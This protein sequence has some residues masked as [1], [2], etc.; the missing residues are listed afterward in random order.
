MPTYTQT[1]LPVDLKSACRC[2]ES[3]TWR[4]Q[5]ISGRQDDATVVD[6][7]SEGR[8]GRTAYGEVPGEEVFFGWGGMEVGRGLGGEFLGF[9]YW[10]ES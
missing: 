1:N 9:T 6:A 4:A 10:I 2:E 7:I 5:R 3:E 8:G